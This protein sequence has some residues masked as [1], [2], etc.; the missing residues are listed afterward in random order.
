MEKRHQILDSSECLKHSHMTHANL[1]R[2][3]NT[4]KVTYSP[5][6]PAQPRMRVATAVRRS[7]KDAMANYIGTVGMII[8]NIPVSRV[9]NY[10]GC[11]Q[12]ELFYFSCMYF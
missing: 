11:E 12:Q 2:A 8:P 9:S 3:T 7:I 1:L 6:A 4:C 5:A 10:H